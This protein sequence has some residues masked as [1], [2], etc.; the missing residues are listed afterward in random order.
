MRPSWPSH[1]SY[2]TLQQRKSWAAHSLWC[3]TRESKKTASSDTAAL[4]AEIL[5]CGSTQKVEAY[6]RTEGQQ[7]WCKCMQR[8]IF[9][10]LQVLTFCI[11]ASEKQTFLHDLSYTAVNSKSWH[12]ILGTKSK[13]L[14]L[15]FH[16]LKIIEIMM[17]CTK[18]YGVLAR[19]WLL[20][21][22]WL[23]WLGPAASTLAAEP[24]PPDQCCYCDP[25]LPPLE[26]VGLPEHCESSSH[27]QLHSQ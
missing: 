25:A 16:F 4:L 24:L 20:V 15:K 3:Q 14:L 9:I 12:W 18:R 6:Q 27:Q 1:D 13:S 17:P 22:P 21:S 19:G 2:P 7:W 5:E 8:L 26:S 10:C 23:D 11:I